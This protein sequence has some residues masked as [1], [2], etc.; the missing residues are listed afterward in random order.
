MFS[1][2]V[3]FFQKK[4]GEKIDA[5]ITELFDSI[6]ASGEPIYKR[7]NPTAVAIAG[8]KYSLIA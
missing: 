4:E 6:E 8:M 5:I 1:E 7:V 3:A 2:N